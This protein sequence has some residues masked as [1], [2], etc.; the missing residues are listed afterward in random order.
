MKEYSTDTGEA[1]PEPNSTE[2]ANLPLAAITAKMGDSAWDV[3]FKGRNGGT[4]SFDVS[5][6]EVVA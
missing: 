3:T 2:L 4:A 1:L 6:I 5:E